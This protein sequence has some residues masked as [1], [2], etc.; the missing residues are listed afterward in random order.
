[1]SYVLRP[2][3]QSGGGTVTFK[4]IAWTANPDAGEYEAYHDELGKHQTSE[5]N[6]SEAD[7]KSI[8]QNTRTPTR[9]G[10]TFLPEGRSSLN[11]ERQSP[12]TMITAASEKRP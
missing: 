7:E 6:Q 10:G 8:Q 1:M 3:Y 11:G 4:M 2:Q 5:R 9:T 12:S